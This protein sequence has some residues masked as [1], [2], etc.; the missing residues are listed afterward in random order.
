[1]HTLLEYEF[2]YTVR[3]SL[4]FEIFLEELKY[5]FIFLHMYVENFPIYYTV[6]VRS[7]GYN[8]F[9]LS[10][11]A[12]N[13]FSALNAFPSL[14]VNPCSFSPFLSFKIILLITLKK[15]KKKRKKRKNKIKNKK[16]T[17]NNRLLQIKYNNTNKMN[18]LLKTTRLHGEKVAC[19]IPLRKVT[20]ISNK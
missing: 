17:K 6:Y 18:P 2:Q 12:H 14:F 19:R 11:A 16:I 3:Y 13:F 5:E 4:L 10:P 1:M 9:S 7:L 20:G 15:K 8:Y